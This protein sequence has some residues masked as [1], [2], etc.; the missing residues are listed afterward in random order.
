MV[1]DV[2]VSELPPCGIYRTRKAIKSI[3]AGRLVYFHNHGDP[4]PGVYLPEGWSN[5]RAR[6]SANGT[7]VPDDFDPKS[8]QALKTEGLYRV[9]A[10]FYCCSKKCTK[11]E[12]DTLVQLGY[13]GNAQALVF[14]PELSP[15]GVNLPERGSIVDDAELKNLTALKVVQSKDQQPEISMPRG[16]I[17]H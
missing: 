17:V 1:H 5:N 7:T 8:L 14:L 13:N 4:G 12:P 16:L 3:E 6:F 11:F 10:M 9:N 2:R 15:R